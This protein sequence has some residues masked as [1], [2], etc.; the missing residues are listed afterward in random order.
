MHNHKFEKECYKRM[1]N[2]LTEFQREKIKEATRFG[3]TA[4]N[5]KLSLQLTCTKDVLYNIRRQILHN[6]KLNEISNMIEEIES[7]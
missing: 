1:R 7:H 6:Q 3:I 2:I 4:Q 5:L